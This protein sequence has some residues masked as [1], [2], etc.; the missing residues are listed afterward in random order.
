MICYYLNQV[1]EAFQVMPSGLKGG[2]NSEQLLIRS[3]IIAFSRL[4]FAAEERHRMSVH[5]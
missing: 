2:D 1:H 3:I 5:V 4:K